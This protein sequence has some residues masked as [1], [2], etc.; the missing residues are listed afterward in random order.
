MSSQ[1]I[2]TNDTIVKEIVRFIRDGMNVDDRYLP[3]NFI[4]I[5]RNQL[6]RLGFSYAKC[7]QVA[8]HLGCNVFEELIYDELDSPDYIPQTTKSE[9][10]IFSQ[11][12]VNAIF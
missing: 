3:D 6:R 12:F 10:Y 7:E 1:K 5:A 11:F 8:T 2:S 4:P 9:N